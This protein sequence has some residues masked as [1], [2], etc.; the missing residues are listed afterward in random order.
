MTSGIFGWRGK[1]LRIDLSKHDISEMETMDY[2]G[3]F[4]GG[5]GIATRIYWEEVNPSVKAFDPENCLIFMTGPLGAT[6]AQGASRFVVVGKSPMLMPEGF[7]YG[8]LGGYFG[9]SLKRAGY[10]GIVIKGCADR[11]SY[12]RI[13]DGHVEILDAGALWGKGTYEVRDALRKEYGDHVHFLTTGVAGERRCRNA[14]LIT[15]HEGSATGGF[16]AVMGSKN[17]KA[18][19]VVGTGRPLA[20]RQK[21][22]SELNRLTIH[23]SKRGILR[24]PVPKDQIRYVKKASCYQCGLDCLRGLF[25][26]ASGKESIRKCQSMVFYM[27]WVFKRPGEPVETAV[28]ATEMCNDVSLCTME[29]GNLIEWLNESYRSGSLTEKETGLALSTIGSR[30]FLEQLIHM[31]AYR[32]GFGDT[33]AEGL[34]RAKQT[35]GHRVPEP[36]LENLSGVGEEGAYSPRVY[37]THSLL[38]P[39]EPRQHMAMLHEISYMIARWLLHR[40]RPDLSPTSADVFRAAAERFWGHPKA[41]D[42]KTY[43]GKAAA[44]AR[45]QDRTYVKDSL[46]LCD[47]AWP[48]MDSFNSADHVGDPTLESRLFTAV[49]GIETDE[50]GLR[51]YGERI[52][53]LQ[54][55]ILLREGRKAKASDAPPEIDF[56][57]PIGRDPLNP[58]LIVPGPGEETVSL[59]GNVLDKTQ[60]E[61]MREEFYDLRGWDRR[62][63][64]QRAETLERLDL[65]DVASVL[66]GMGL[67]ASSRED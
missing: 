37:V 55:A 8:N 46:V 42:M 9:P 66:G 6:G 15:D 60:F 62:T 53:N 58:H 32:K 57:V 28:D 47:S 24:M 36:F 38:Y 25:R 20:A 19:S 27:P 7:C 50:A 67:V 12:I 17:L 16:G 51:L 43:E 39:F 34:L 11:P 21:E 31:M 13:D 63:G 59:K 45:I 26:T 29:M 1:I 30:E 49:T 2:A 54:R 65:A 44:A 61:K 52:F 40:I 22:L 4:L 23:L 3:P 10:D 14:T 48:I 18:I 5:R 33:L 56:K 41:W 35:L 64:L